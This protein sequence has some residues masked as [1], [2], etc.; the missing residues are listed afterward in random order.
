MG[1]LQEEG[2]DTPLKKRL[3]HPA[4]QAVSHRRKSLLRFAWGGF[5]ATEQHVEH[6]PERVEIHGIGVRG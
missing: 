6:D 1:P 3:S 4:Q 5:A 2:R